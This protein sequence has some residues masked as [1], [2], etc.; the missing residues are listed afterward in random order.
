MNDPYTYTPVDVEWYGSDLLFKYPSGQTEI[1]PVPRGFVETILN[2]FGDF[3]VYKFENGVYEKKD[4]QAITAP[5]RVIQVKRTRQP[6][7]EVTD[8]G[9]FA[10]RNIK[11]GDELLF[12]YGDQ[13]PWADLF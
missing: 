10:L 9:I 11:P 12:E 6:N 2:R 7:V 4:L 5:L 13:Y 3:Y 1:V 8:E